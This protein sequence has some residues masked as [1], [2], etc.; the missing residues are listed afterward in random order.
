[1]VD[2]SVF[3]TDDLS[4]LEGSIPSSPTSISRVYLDFPCYFVKKIKQVAW[5]DCN[6]RSK[7][8]SL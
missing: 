5:F 1:M 3:Q 6:L 2:A 8:M 4:G 7:F